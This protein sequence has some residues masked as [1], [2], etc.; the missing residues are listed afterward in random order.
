MLEAIII[1]ETEL[2][3]QNLFTSKLYKRDVKKKIENIAIYP[4]ILSYMLIA[5]II[6]IQTNDVNINPEIDPILFIPK[7]PLKFLI[8]GRTEFE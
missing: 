1:T 7:N 2:R 6:K 8:I 5:L 4:S 3:V